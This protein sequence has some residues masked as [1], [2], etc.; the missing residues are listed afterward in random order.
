MV[1]KLL[2]KIL[3]GF[4]CLFGFVNPVI[5]GDNFGELLEAVITHLQCGDPDNLDKW[6]EE[7]S[8]A[9]K[10]DQQQRLAWN[11]P[12]EEILDKGASLLALQQQLNPNNPLKLRLWMSFYWH[13]KRSRSLDPILTT[14]FAL[15]LRELQRRTEDMWSPEWQNMWQSLPKSL[16]IILQ[17]RWLCLQHKRQMVYV[18]SGYKLELGVNSNC[19]MWQIQSENKDP[20]QRLINFCDD[21]SWFFINLL[22]S[23]AEVD[24]LQSNPSSKAAKF[25]VFNEGGYFGDAS[26]S[27]VQCQW[28]VN[29][30]TN[31]PKILNENNHVS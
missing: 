6:T 17:S 20:W 21:S 13:L 23:S 14:N 4:C 19:S 10:S 24:M 9:L 7:M 2:V 31:L 15:K 12:W 18:V 1:V 28:Q 22:H 29:D 11:I 5:Y 3:M 8:L 27:D 26:E 16:K 25:C 30:C